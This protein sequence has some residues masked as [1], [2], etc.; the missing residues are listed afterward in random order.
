M[1]ET[2]SGCFFSEHSVCGR[3]CI[4]TG[5]HWRSKRWTPPPGRSD[6]GIKIISHANVA[7]KLLPGQR[8][9]MQWM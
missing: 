7:K 5:T 1:K 3:T 8:L 6:T 4:L 9:R 2:V